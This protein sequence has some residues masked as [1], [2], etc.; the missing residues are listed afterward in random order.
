[1]LPVLLES[2]TVSLEGGLQVAFSVLR[3]DQVCGAGT[4]SQ[5]GAFPTTPLL[6]SFLPEGGGNAAYEDHVTILLA[7]GASRVLTEI[8]VLY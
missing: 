3:S 8:W 2:Y 1:M 7:P 4:V 6:L 5:D